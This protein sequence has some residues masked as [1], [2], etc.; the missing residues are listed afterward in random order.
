MTG[1]WVSGVHEV[2]GHWFVYTDRGTYGP[3]VSEDAAWTYI[4]R[5]RRLGTFEK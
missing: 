5:E 3:F 4:A 1:E 2:N